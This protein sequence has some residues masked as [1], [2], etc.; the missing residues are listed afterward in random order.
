MRNGIKRGDM[1]GSLVSIDVEWAMGW[2]I[3]FYGQAVMNQFATP[4]EL[5]HWPEDNSPN[6]LGW[7]GGVEYNRDIAGYRSQFYL[8]AVYTDPYLYILSSPFASFIWMRRLSELTRKKLRYSWIGYP[9][10]RDVIQVSLG[11]KVYK[12]PFGFNWVVSY[13][14]RGEHSILWDWEKGSSAVQQH[15]PSGVGEHN[16]RISF[17]FQWQVMDSLSFN[18]FNACQWV[19]NVDHQS[20]VTAFGSEFA[21]SAKYILGT[22]NNS[23]TY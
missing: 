3:S 20:G 10:G 15:S 13:L 9:E 12:V 2:G 5:E 7:L 22:T 21:I 23:V 1:N 4:Y 6:G 18:I 14:V 11:S 16:W 17:E 8:E 19:L